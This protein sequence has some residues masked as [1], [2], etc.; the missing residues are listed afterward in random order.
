[1]RADFPCLFVSSKGVNQHPCLPLPLQ[2]MQELQS[3]GLLQDLPGGLG[4]LGGGGAAPGAGGAAGGMPDLG[5]LMGMLGGGAGGLGGLGGFGA[6]PPP[7][8]PEEAYATQLQ[9]L[10]DMV[11]EARGRDYATCQGIALPLTCYT[12]SICL[13]IASHCRAPARSM[14]APFPARAGFLRPRSQHP[15]PGGCWRQRQRCCGAPAGV[16]VR[17]HASWRTG[18]RAASPHKS[19]QGGPLQAGGAAAPLLF[20]SCSRLAAEHLIL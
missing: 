9:Q 19:R 4:P 20:F 11:S 1:M 10:Q 16:H 2:A 17:P 6:P 5:A 13:C 8:N 15:G 7:A 12:S 18:A 14:A 3:T